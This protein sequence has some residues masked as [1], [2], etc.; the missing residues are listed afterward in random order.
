MVN[1]RL[2]VYLEKHHKLSAH[3]Y[4]FRKNRTTIDNIQVLEDAVIRAFHEKSHLTSLF[5]DIEKAYE[6]V[7]SYR[8]LKQLEDWGLELSKRPRVR[9]TL[10]PYSPIP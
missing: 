1:N 9:L 8:I 3:Q 10:E 6:R 5:L 2:V 4:G 7:W